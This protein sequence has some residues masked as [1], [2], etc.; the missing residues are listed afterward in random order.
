MPREKGK[1]EAFIKVFTK[2]NYVIGWAAQPVPSFELQL[3]E[4]SRAT[5]LISPISAKLEMW[6]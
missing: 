5:V 1:P 3:F 6:L 2:K 4:R